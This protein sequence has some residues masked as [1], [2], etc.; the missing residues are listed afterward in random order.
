M[1][2]RASTKSGFTPSAGRCRASISRSATPVKSWFVPAAYS[3]AIS[4]RTKPPGKRCA[5]AG[6]TP[7]MPVIS[8]LTAISSCWA[9]SRTWFIPRAANAISPITSR[10][11]SNSA[12]M[13]RTPPCSGAAA[14]RCR[15]SSASTGKP[16][17]CGPNCAAFP[18]SPMPTCRRSRRSS[19][20]SPARSSTSTAR[21]RTGCNCANSSACTR[22]SMPTTAR[23]REPAR[24]A[25]TSSRS[26]TSRS[27]MRS[28]INRR[29]C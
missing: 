6:C 18:T 12:P 3:A 26:A 21:C 8:N 14:T 16:S 27:S 24:S 25:A 15:R 7:A 28:T 10:T 29:R 4:T 2:S 11:A 1:P 13:S 19:T 22:N 20:S 17:A 5:M 9:G 23:S